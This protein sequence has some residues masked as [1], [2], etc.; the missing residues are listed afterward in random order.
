[1]NDLLAWLKLQNTGIGTYIEFQKRTL[2]LAAACA[3]QA[4]LFQ[5]FAQLSARFVM[6]YEDMPMD[7]AIADHALVR[8]TRLVEAAAKSPGLSAAE[9]LRLLNEIASADLGRVEALAGAGG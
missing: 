5:L 6:T 4:A 2:R 9:Q 7:V 3:D 1:M 8:L